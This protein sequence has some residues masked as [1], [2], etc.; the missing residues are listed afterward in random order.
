M[1]RS[2]RQWL[3]GTSAVAGSMMLTNASRAQAWPNKPI[4]VIVPYPVGGAVDV[5]TRLI[6]A[7][8]QNTLGQAIVVENRPG[9]NANLGPDH[10][11][12]AAADGYT[13]LA[14]ATYLIA[15][16]IIEK[17]LR[18]A[19]RD[20]AAVARFTVAPNLMV[21]PAASPYRSV[22][23]LAEAARSR[24]GALNYGEAG[25]GA[26]QTLAI[27]MFKKVARI[28]MQSVMYKGSPPILT[29]LANGTL[30]MSVVP[31]NVAMAS[32][33]GGRIRALASTSARRSPLIPDVPT[34][35]ES[36][37]PEATVVSWYGFHV[38]TGTPAEAIA[39]LSAATQAA[40]ASDEVRQ[41][42]AN[43][44][45]ETSFLDTPAFDA[46]LREDDTRWQAFMST[47]G[48][49]G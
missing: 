5:M 39:R 7:H 42:T 40:C 18:W 1:R 34:L 41:R 30:A 21:V 22:K 49:P 32:L 35:A 31:L 15:N 44:G 17:G 16:P 6:S 3:T 47:L 9:A 8:M 29:D 11:S 23:E 14:S 2:R 27:E 28:E 45:G 48:R 33:S 26:P 12:K 13:V 38:P 10:V 36:G 20:F 46:F 43:V 25:P 4:R 19:P 24:P 37:Y